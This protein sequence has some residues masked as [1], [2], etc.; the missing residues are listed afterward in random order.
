MA[1]SQREHGLAAVERLNLRL[2]IDA[3]HDGML[4]RGHIEA[5]DIADLGDEVGI[6]QQGAPD[7]DQVELAPLEQVHRGIQARRLGG[8]RTAP[9]GAVQEDVVESDRADCDHRRRNHLRRRARL[10]QQLRQLRRH[11][12]PRLG[13]PQLGRI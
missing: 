6:R 9:V 2:L 8:D 4:G 13:H 12:R 1:R 7:G 5:D 3:Q 11:L 10:V